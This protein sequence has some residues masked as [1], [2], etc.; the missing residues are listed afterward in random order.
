[1]MVALTRANQDYLKA[2]YLEAETAS[3]GPGSELVS[4]TAIA[5]R[6]NVSAAA[7]TSMLKRLDSLGLVEHLPYRGAALTEG[8]LNAALEVVRHH[9]LLETYLARSLDVPWEEV[10][11]EAEGLEHVLSETLEERISEC[12]GHPPV[13]PH[14]HPIPSRDLEMPAGLGKLLWDTAD[15][16]RVTVAAVSDVI[17]EALRYLGDLGIR[18]GT[19]LVIVGRGPIGGPLFVRLCEGGDD[20]PHALSR[21]IAES[22]W[23]S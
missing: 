21:E 8:G 20:T 2:I 17:P 7:A 5:R 16:Q 1:M 18:P 12:L 3:G 4:T 22:V 10:H 23:V 15:E 19:T 14:G 11:R 6:L 13:D 9:R